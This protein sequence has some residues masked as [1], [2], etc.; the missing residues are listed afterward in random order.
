VPVDPWNPRWAVAEEVAAAVLRRHPDAVHAIGVHGSLAHG[1][2]AEGSDVD[3]VVVTHRPGI[4]PQ[5]TS[6]RI[7]GVI[8]DCGVISADEYLAHASTLSTSWPLAADQYVTTKP[9]YDPDGWHDR[10]RDT[11]LA[12]LAEAGGAEFVALA[13]EAWGPARST[14]DKAMR[15]AV[16]YDTEGALLTLGEARLAAA[17]VDGLLGRTYFRSSADA[18]RRTGSG[19]LDLGELDRHLVEQA[20]ELARRGAPVDATADEVADA[21]LARS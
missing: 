8:V 10:L 17:L 11:H 6:R 13:R 14:V 7:D 2:D 15:L 4:G 16:R 18:V 9:L 12:R 21:H 19:S 5:P 1:D 3:M 20:A